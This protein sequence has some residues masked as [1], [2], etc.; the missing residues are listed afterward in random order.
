MTTPQHAIRQAALALF[1]FPQSVL[2]VRTGFV[3]QCAHTHQT[4]L[5][6]S[7]CNNLKRGQ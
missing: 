1:L 3:C 6:A 4:A 7:N 2:K 5:F